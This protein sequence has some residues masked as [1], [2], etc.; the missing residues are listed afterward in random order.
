MGEDEK[1]ALSGGRCLHG[2][3]FLHRHYPDQVQRS[4]LFVFQDPSQPKILSSR[5]AYLFNVY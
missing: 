1:N 5:L 2:L 3:F 4:D